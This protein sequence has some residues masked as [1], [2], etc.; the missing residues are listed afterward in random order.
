LGIQVSTYIITKVFQSLQF[1]FV[2][3]HSFSI[4]YPF[5]QTNT[6]RYHDRGALWHDILFD[7]WISAPL[8][9]FRIRRSTDLH[10]CHSYCRKIDSNNARRLAFSEKE[11]LLIP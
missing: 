5:I 8:S 2:W 7:S 1:K 4:C 10:W 9:G 3:I 6:N 11:A